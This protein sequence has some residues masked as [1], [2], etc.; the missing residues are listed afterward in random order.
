MKLPFNLPFG[1]KVKTEYFFGFLLRDEKINAVVFEETNKVLKICGEHEEQLSTTLNEI[2]YEELL[3]LTDRTLSMAEESLPDGA[4]AQ[5]TIFGVKGDWVDKSQITKE[6]LTKLRK[7]S[8]E[9]NL[10]PIGFLVISEAIIHLLT[11]QEGAPVSAILVEIGRA[12]ITASMVRAG[13]V[14]ETHTQ[15]IEN[16]ASQTTDSILHH[17]TNHEI[18]PSRILLFDGERGK[19]LQQEFI[20]HS[21]SKSLPFLHVPQITI[22]PAQYDVQ[23]ILYGTATQ[24]GFEIGS[25]ELEHVKTNG[26][27]TN[28]VV[29]SNAIEEG[30]EVVKH[31][32]ASSNDFGFV[33]NGD[34]ETVR[35]IL[36]QPEPKGTHSA[37]SGQ[38][39]ETQETEGSKEETN[40]EEVQDLPDTRTSTR[41]DRSNFGKF[42]SII[43][44][45]PLSNIT[46]S[47][48]GIPKSIGKMLP[49]M[50]RDGKPLFILG[51]IIIAIIAMAF[52]YFTMIS[53]TIIIFVT[54][55]S[56]ENIQTIIFSPQQPTDLAE[57]RIFVETINVEKEGNLSGPATGT[58]EVGEKAK[59]NVTI[60]SSLTREQTLTEGTSI[61]SSNGLLFTLDNAVKIASSSGLSDIKSIT[62]SVTAKIIGKEHN[63]PSGTKFSV[64]TFDRSSVE[65]KNDTAFTGGSKKE[66]TVVSQKDVDRLLA[67]LPKSLQPKAQDEIKSKVSSD[68]ELLIGFFKTT[69]V[70][71]ELSKKVSEEAASV[72]LKATISFEGFSYKKDDA[73][74]LFAEILKQNDPSMTLSGDSISYSAKSSKQEKNGD[75]KI[76]MSI[77][78]G[79]VPKIDQEKLT[80][81]LTGKSFDDAIGQII[82][83]PQIADAKI[84]LSPPIPFLPK[85]LPRMAKN[86]HVVITYQ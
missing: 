47:L 51:G 1:K 20:S 26:K 15:V 40:F 11:L 70:D 43:S 23:A 65:A 19:S 75:T 85:N 56:I 16:S 66:V 84:S 36:K 34:I 21:W 77:K 28:E 25:G 71:K 67:E 24:M 4:E 53:A 74:Q 22:L 6:H 83:M 82:D 52:F 80:A 58:K 39:E 69:I 60:I 81:Q 54:P 2:S 30:E 64:G 8:E 10:S 32:P 62:A 73:K 57:K 76:E 17:F 5:K 46:K 12:H 48:I 79:L 7:L 18:L 59:G 45:L 55:K 13:K 27:R 49:A 9:L 3:Q 63:L 38:A 29:A 33:V 61:T 35:G 72:N 14:L 86:I 50:P 44:S 41:K 31:S 37:S 78:G 68:R 42:S